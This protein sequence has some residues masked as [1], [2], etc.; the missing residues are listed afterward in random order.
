MTPPKPIPAPSSPPVEFYDTIEF[1]EEYVSPFTEEY[2]VTQCQ[3][4]FLHVPPP[5]SPPCFAPIDE[6]MEVGENYFIPPTTKECEETQNQRKFPHV[7]PPPSPACFAPIDELMEVGEDY[8]IP[9]T[10]KECEE[11]QNERKFPHVP[12]PS[13]STTNSYLL[14]DELINHQ[15]AIFISEIRNNMETKRNQTM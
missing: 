15:I 4:M 11:M 7:P 9:P 2:Q 1:V 5:P 12:P 3:Q 6:L 14:T 10:P 13:S 8:F